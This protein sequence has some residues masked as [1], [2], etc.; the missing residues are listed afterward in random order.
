MKS[1]LGILEAKIAADNELNLG[2]PAVAAAEVPMVIAKKTA[3][4]AAVATAVPTAVVALKSAP[5]AAVPTVEVT[6]VD[7]VACLAVTPT[8]E[9]TDV[10]T[11]A[12]LAVTPTV[13]VTD[14][15]TVACLAVTPT[16][17]VTDVDTVACL[18][19]APTVEVTAVAVKKATPAVAGA[20][21]EAL[22]VID[23]AESILKEFIE[24]SEAA[25]VADELVKR[26]EA[27][28]ADAYNEAIASCTVT[29]VQRVIPMI[30]TLNDARRV[31]SRK[32]SL[33]NSTKAKYKE[34]IDLL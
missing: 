28:S 8:V 14:V 24:T 1:L 13:E 23:N 27:S 2:H 34:L 9:V 19:V 18:A 7:T 6:D 25:K 30:Q 12:C 4:L 33:A 26:L 22:A 10:D 15:D 31:A 17:E 32:H 5:L 11:V 29:T 16:V 20:T 3:P 21:S